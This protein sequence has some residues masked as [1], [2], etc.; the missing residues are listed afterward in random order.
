MEIEIGNGFLCFRYTGFCPELRDHYG[1]TYGYA[2]RY[3]IQQKPHLKER[4][5]PVQYRYRRHEK[6]NGKLGKYLGKERDNKYDS[7]KSKHRTNHLD[8]SEAKNRTD[9]TVG[10][11][12][13]EFHHLDYADGDTHRGKCYRDCE[14]VY[15]PTLKHASTSTRDDKVLKTDHEYP[16]P[17]Y[18]FIQGFAGNFISEF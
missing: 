9:R 15:Q 1:E 16:C 8:A 18:I 11:A 7:T 13:K 17:K 6:T 14:S 5:A 3:I 4:L 12:R 10:D 2:T